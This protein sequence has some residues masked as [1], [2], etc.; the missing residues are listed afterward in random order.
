[1]QT[2][3]AEYHR[4]PTWRESERSRLDQLLYRVS[5][6]IEQQHMTLPASTDDCSDDLS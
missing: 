5:K 3:L 6:S 4:A 1:M 2:V